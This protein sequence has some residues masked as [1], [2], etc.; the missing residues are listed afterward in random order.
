MNLYTEWG[1]KV[2]GVGGVHARP[3]QAGNR[4]IL[5]LY[6]ETAPITCENF[7]TLCSYGETLSSNTT[8]KKKPAPIGECGKPL[9]YKDSIIHRVVPGFV[10]QGGDFV[11]GNGSGGESIFNGKKFKDERAGLLLKHDRKGILS[12]GNSGKN[13]N[14]SQFFI[15]FG[16]APQCDGKHVVFGEVVSGWEVLSEIETRGTKSGAPSVPI[17][18]TSS[19]IY[20]PFITPSAGYWFDQPD[21]SYSGSSPVFMCKCVLFICFTSS[22]II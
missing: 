21:D 20:E 15:T 7:S 8:K 4:L 10:M 18:I 16:P 17:L 5:K 3:P 6:W 11:F 14:T 9:S 2:A 1:S 12:M 19:G 22:L 13:S